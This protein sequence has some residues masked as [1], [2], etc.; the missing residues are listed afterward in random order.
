MNA[1]TWTTA[2]VVQ[3]IEKLA[4]LDSSAIGGLDVR[5]AVAS[6]PLRRRLRAPG[7]VAPGA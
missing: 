6:R 7:C 5:R 1:N 4:T 2:S 3:K